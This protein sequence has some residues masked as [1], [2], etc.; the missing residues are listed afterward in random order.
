MARGGFRPGAGRP[1][2]AVAKDKKVKAAETALTSE[3]A[4]VRRFKTALEFAMAVINGEVDAGMADR[5]R[6][7]IAAMP[8]QT[9]RM[10]DAAPGKKEQAEAAARTAERGSQWEAL[11]N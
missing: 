11:L 9:P 7:A 6:L 8:Y 3:K 2:G 10:A 1:V 5:V 4:S